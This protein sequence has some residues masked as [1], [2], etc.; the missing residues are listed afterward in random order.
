MGSALGSEG[1]GTLSCSPSLDIVKEKKLL[2]KERE[3][4]QKGISR[5]F[6]KI[7]KRNNRT[8]PWYVDSNQK[9]TL[10]CSQ[11]EPSIS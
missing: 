2:K 11:D 8:C 1:A 7:T 9:R 5:K 3:K 6:E 4:R 10:T